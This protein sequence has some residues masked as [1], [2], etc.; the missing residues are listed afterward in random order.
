MNM[1][2]MKQPSIFEGGE[3][4]EALVEMAARAIE[5][6]MRKG[7]PGMGVRDEG[8]TSLGN[9]TESSKLFALRLAAEDREH[10]EVAFLDT[11]HRLIEVK[12]LFSGTLD[13][14]EVHPRIVAREAMMLNASGVVLAHNHPSGSP[15]PSAADRAVTARI[16]QALAL[17][18]VR[19][20]D[21]IIVW[22]PRESAT[23]SMC[24]RGLI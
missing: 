23:T 3:D 15:E 1:K 21:H 14:C 8:A 16:K 5:A 10:F 19:L 9:H 13:G 22:G 18:D 11:R 2:E 24:A 7:R 12:R 20:L 6:R 17:L 4:A